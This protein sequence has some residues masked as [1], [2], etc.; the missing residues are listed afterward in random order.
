LKPYENVPGFC[1]SVTLDTIREHQHALGPG[2]YVGSEAAPDDGE[3]LDEKIARL[4]A[5]I[6][7]AFAHRVELQEQVLAAL[8]SLR[9]DVR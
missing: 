1:A 7:G 3:A 6:R 5:E 4:T 8:D 2:R 9:A